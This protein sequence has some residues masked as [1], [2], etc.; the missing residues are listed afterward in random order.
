MQ[1][2]IWT[3]RPF[4]S[5]NDSVIFFNFRPDRAR[6]IT[7][8]LVDESF[9]GTQ[10]APSEN[11]NQNSQTNSQSG[12]Q[13]DGQNGSYSENQDY[14]AGGVDKTNPDTGA[15]DHLA[16]AAVSALAATV[17]SKKR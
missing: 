3:H 13:S 7:R 16:L 14:Q 8:T 17:I 2:S 11:T 1:R 5:A 4:P 9:A 10:Q 6:E 15:E 12:S